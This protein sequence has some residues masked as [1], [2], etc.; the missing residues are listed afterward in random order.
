[1]KMSMIAL[2]IVGLS[3]TMLADL[4]QTSQKDIAVVST[5]QLN[6][7]GESSFDTKKGELFSL[8]QPADEKVSV[9]EPIRV[10]LKLKEKA[11][12][13]L[14]AVSNES[15]KAY[16]ILPNRFESFNIYSGK[17]LYVMPERSADYRFVSDAPGTETLYI[18]ASTYKQDFAQLMTQFGKSEV[19][20]FKTTSSKA[21]ESFMKEI[22][23]VPATTH[24]AKVEVRKLQINVGGQN[25]IAIAPES[26]A[27]VFLSSGKTSYHSGDT[28]TIKY[29]SD[30]EGYVYLMVVNPDDSISLL[31]SREVEQD[32][33]Y[34]LRQRATGEGK[35]LLLAYFSKY[36]V[37][38][39]SKTLSAKGL[40]NKPKNT[41]S[42]EALSPDYYQATNQ[43]MIII[44]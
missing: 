39:P 7:D 22:L 40:Q 36:K 9:G 4:N 42:L 10:A 25:Q 29:Q 33:N 6:S 38:D 18:I 13:Y 12:I 11:Y 14:I 5:E 44:E 16:M 37:K 21:A 27:R 15:N 19:G 2:A 24:N 20:G 34:T 30:E 28:V 35:H 41:K 23:V 31:D 43:H 8:V 32:R 17:K 26:N 1:M 3:T